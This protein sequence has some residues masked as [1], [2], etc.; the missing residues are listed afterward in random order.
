MGFAIPQASG[1]AVMQSHEL[2]VQAW[3]PCK[4]PRSAIFA[5]ISLAIHSTVDPSIVCFKQTFKQQVLGMGTARHMF[6]Y[7]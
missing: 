6:A 4:A 5:A 1:A 7:P 2:D 3:G